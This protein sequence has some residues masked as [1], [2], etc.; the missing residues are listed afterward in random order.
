MDKYT[1][2]ELAYKNGYAK[3]YEDGEKSA[4]DHMGRLLHNHECPVGY[5]C[6]SPFCIECLKIHMERG[7]SHEQSQNAGLQQ[8]LH[9]QQQSGSEEE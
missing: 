6:M 5:R 2:T 9:P 4:N 1:A 3:G 7:E 8:A